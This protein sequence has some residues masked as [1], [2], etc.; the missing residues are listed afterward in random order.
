MT[1]LPNNIDPAILSDRKPH[2]VV[3]GSGFG[4]LAAAIRLGA[5]NYRVTVL[6]KLDKPGGR[7]YV[8]ERDGFKFDAGPTIIT[9]PFLLKELWKL[10]GRDFDKEIDLRLMN[11]FYQIR[12]DDGKTFDYSGDLEHVKT[13]IK[14]FNKKDVAGFERFLE[15]SEKIFNVGFEQLGHVPFNSIT[16]MLRIVPS[17][18][19]LK[20]YHSV[21]GL[22][23]KY[24]KDPH[25]R[26]AM[27][28]HPLL[29]GGNPFS[30]TSIYALISFLEQRWGVHSVM[31]GTGQLITGLA[32][33]IEQQGNQI[34][35]NSE[36]EEITTE[37]SIATGVRLKSGETIKSD[38][39]VSNGD[40]AWTMRHMLS[41]KVRTRWTNKRIRK[42]KYSNG[43]FVWYFGT[44]RTYP[45]VKHHT[46]LMGPRYK[47]LVEDIFNNKILA[48]D[49]SLYLHRPTATDPSMAPSG[50]DTFYALSPVPNLSADIDW[51]KQAEPYRKAIEKRLSETILPDLENNI[52]TSF[53]TTPLD[54]KNRLLSYKGAGFSFEP[55]LSQSAWFRPHNLCKEVKNLYFVGAGTHPGAGVPG[56][57]SS[58]R[59]LDSIVPNAKDFNYA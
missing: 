51:K 35:Y 5:R 19:K 23:A 13:Q 17:M 48:K 2:A 27:S 11:P 33:L 22:V 56:V 50:C 32:G 52:A 44:Q 7:A 39:V 26:I 58:A 31:G 43:L 45:E 40:S 15:T 10:C 24:I 3:I 59:V 16:D 41:E 4:G 12:F 20:S 14:K 42:S 18:V 54:F 29:I 38:I 30:A 55:L 8:Y 37:N 9:A 47:E 21:Y 34:R 46:I 57:L 49:F 28:F 36:V 1:Y 6:E 53:V 25:L